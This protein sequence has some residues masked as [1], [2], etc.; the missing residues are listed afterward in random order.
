MRQV[1]EDC[2]HWEFGE[3]EV[4]LLRITNSVKLRALED[5]M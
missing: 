5:E 4:E 2:W 3:Q 1:C